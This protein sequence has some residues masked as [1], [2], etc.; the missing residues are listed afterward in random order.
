MLISSIVDK[1]GMSW[2]SQKVHL[3]GLLPIKPPT[4]RLLMLLLMGAAFNAQAAT[5]TVT[6][7]ADSGANSLRQVIADASAGD[8]INFSTDVQTITL[9]SGEIVINKALTI[10]GTGSKVTISGNNASRIFNIRGGTGVI[11]TLRALTFTGGTAT[12]GGAVYVDTNGTVV[13]I[14][15]STFTGN[16]AD[17]GGAVY[18]KGWTATTINITNSTFTD[19][20]AINGGAGAVFGASAKINI[21]NSTFVDNTATAGRAGYYSYFNARGQVKNSIFYNNT[22]A[23]AVVNCGWSTYSVATANNIGCGSGLGNVNPLLGPLQDNG[24]ETWSMKPGTNSPAID[25]GNECSDSDQRGFSR[26]TDGNRDGSANCDIGAIEV[27]TLTVTTNADSGANSLRQVIADASAGDTINF[28][29]DVQTITLSSGEIVINK[30][31][32]I[33]GTGSKVTISGNNASRIFNIRG[34]TG[35]IV[36]LRALTFTGGTATTGGAVYVDTNGTVVNIEKSTFTGNK[37]DNGGAVY[38]KGWTATTINITNSTFTDNHAINGGAGAVFGASAKI[39]ITNSTFVDNT[40]T[41]GRAGYYSYFNARGQVKNSIF[42]NNTTAGAVVNCGWSTYS[43]AT[44]NNIGCGSGLGNVNPLLGP[45]QDNGGETWSMKPGTNS[46]AIDAGNECSDSDQRGFSRPTDGNEDGNAD[47]D[48]GAIEVQALD[49][50]QLGPVIGQ[51]VSA[52]M[53]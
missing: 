33:D 27:P 15:K 8:T 29:T 39:N 18:G 32:T 20:H 28:S 16:K 7:N 34:G 21:T 50:E 51:P 30:A 4:S 14:E 5:L 1:V 35:V 23:G 41:A 46:P 10:D 19:N 11:V 43:V 44:A 37:A 25:A 22:T 38:G 52:A 31:L 9:S 13:N 42:Y 45:L 48:I 3:R 53:V 26:P 2:F 24:G 49:S 40:A 47:C 36:T 17:N 12:T 6:T